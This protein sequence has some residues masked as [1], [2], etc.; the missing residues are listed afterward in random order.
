MKLISISQFWGKN[1][2]LRISVK[3]SIIG[4]NKPFQTKNYDDP[5]RYVVCYANKQKKRFEKKKTFWKKSFV[6]K[7]AQYLLTWLPVVYINVRDNFM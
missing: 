1:K 7:Y 6:P 3:L 4:S 5:Y 2:T